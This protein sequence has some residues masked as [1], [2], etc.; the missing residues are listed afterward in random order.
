MKPWCDATVPTRERFHANSTTFLLQDGENASSVSGQLLPRAEKPVWD[1]DLP[2]SPGC[3]PPS[4]PMTLRAELLCLSWPLLQTKTIITSLSK[5]QTS[6]LWGLVENMQKK[7]KG[8]SIFMSVV[9]V[10]SMTAVQ[11][12]P[13]EQGME[14]QTLTGFKMERNKTGVVSFDSRQLDW[15]MRTSL[16]PCVF[17]PHLGFYTHLRGLKTHP[18][19]RLCTWK[20]NIVMGLA[21]DFSWITQ[22]F[23]SFLI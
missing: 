1:R 17:C 3:S 21:G 9:N 20:R 19:T 18:Q 4:L 7:C 5:L 2:L 12:C 14:N 11:M 22:E 10:R 13:E 8:I 15:A 23:L 6:I 16:Q